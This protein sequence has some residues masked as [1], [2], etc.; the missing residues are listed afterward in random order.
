[1]FLHKTHKMFRCNFI[2]ADLTQKLW[3]VELYMNE[4]EID[5]TGKILSQMKNQTFR[6]NTGEYFTKKQV[7]LDLIRVQD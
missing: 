6:F 7:E 5:K 2:M 3:I 4:M 1:M